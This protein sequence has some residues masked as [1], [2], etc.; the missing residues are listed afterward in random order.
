[1]KRKDSSRPGIRIIRDRHI[2]RMLQ[3]NEPVIR[4]EM[5]EWMIQ[6]NEANDG[7]GKSGKPIFGE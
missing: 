4:D 5:D 1:M 3:E 2:V 7:N 6:L